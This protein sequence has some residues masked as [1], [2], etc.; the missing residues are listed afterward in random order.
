MGGI[1]FINK[2]TGSYSMLFDCI[3]QIEGGKGRAPYMNGYDNQDKPDY[4]SIHKWS[5]LLVET[6]ILSKFCQSL[7]NSIIQVHI[8]VSFVIEDFLIEVTGGLSLMPAYFIIK[9]VALEHSSQ[10]ACLKLDICQHQ[11]AGGM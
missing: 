7:S 3:N 4:L 6:P 11:Q 8:I 9:C 10:V 2:I 1:Q 5:Y